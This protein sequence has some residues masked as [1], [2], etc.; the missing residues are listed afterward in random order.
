MCSP[1]KFIINFTYTP[2]NDIIVHKN[3]NSDSLSRSTTCSVGVRRFLFC[4]SES[5][6]MV[7]STFSQTDTNSND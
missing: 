3:Y 5:L 2:L 4:L 6:Q 1:P 7:I